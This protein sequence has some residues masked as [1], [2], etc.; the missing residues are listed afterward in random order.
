MADKRLRS[1]IDLYRV[2]VQDPA[3][4]VCL[5]RIN[6]AHAVALARMCELQSQSTVPQQ[7][8]SATPSGRAP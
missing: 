7:Q 1:W 3:S 2:A 6:E 5:E 8:G 4:D